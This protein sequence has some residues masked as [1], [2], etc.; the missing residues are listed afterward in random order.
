MR[1]I[2]TVISSLFAKKTGINLF[3]ILLLI[4][5][6]FTLGIS[7]GQGKPKPVQNNSA[8][9]LNLKNITGIVSETDVSRYRVIFDLQKNG[10]WQAADKIIAT[11][12]VGNLL[13]HVYAQRYLHP[14]KYRSKYRE[15][16]AWLEKYSDHPHAS[17]IYKLALRRKPKNANL[18]KKP[19]V[20]QKSRPFIGKR[21]LGYLTY[22]PRKRLKSIDRQER[23]KILRQMRYYS[24]KGWTKSYKNLIK[25]SRSKKLLHAGQ[26]DRA[27]A[28][29]AAGYY[30]DGRDQWAY[31]WAKKAV[32]RSG[33]YLPEAH[34]VAALSAWRLARFKTSH[35]H[36]VAVSKSAYASPWLIS[37]GAFW[38]ARA[39]IKI[40]KPM[41]Y[42]RHLEIASAY[43]RTFYG[44]LARRL[45]GLAV[46]YNWVPPPLEKQA[47]HELAAAPGGQRAISL[48]QIGEDELAEGELNLLFQISKPE[49]ARAMVAVVDRANMPSLAMRIGNLL[50]TSGSILFDSTTYPAPMLASKYANEYDRSLILALIR[51]ESRFNP[52]A[53]SRRGARGL[54]QLMPR[55][56]SFVARDRKLK[57]SK[58]NRDALFDPETNLSLGQKYINILMNDKA[59]KGDLFRMLAAWNGGPGN[60]N[61]WNREV[62][63]NGDPL[64]FIESLPSKET[65]IFI[66]RVLTNY[67]IYQAR[68]GNS[69]RSLDL[70]ARGYWPAYQS[71]SRSEIELAE[72]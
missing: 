50:V 51:Q 12:D 52:M 24:R 54:L 15:L 65:R 41:F 64:L 30:A 6:Y 48:L 21:Y 1:F 23:R 13:G 10:E 69:N 31:N 26:L 17:R 70:V 55:T 47:L 58:K 42:T 61:K 27:K 5:G 7:P 38:A 35:M 25:N 43:P 45:L 39:S 29:L 37:A 4:T 14:T 19:I 46:K 62:N 49:L 20:R 22:N 34:W 53:K 66:E 63:Y 59:V 40:R 60:L 57:G 72:D 56:A 71:L 2:F 16:R 8:I 68:F 9:S 11:L 67:W 3:G 32:D 18:P 36:F 28:G 44:I 33:K